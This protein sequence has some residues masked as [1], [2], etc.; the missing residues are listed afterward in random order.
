MTTH[1]APAESEFGKGPRRNK[2]AGPRASETARG[3]A[4]RRRDSLRNRVGEER[5]RRPTSSQ[6]TESRSY[7]CTG[8][9]V[10]DDVLA[11]VR[12]IQLRASRVVNDVL[13]GHYH[14]TFRG[15]G[16]EFDE[17]RVYTPGDDVRSIDW[18][19][20]ARTGVPHIKRYVE[21]RELTV[22]LL[23]DVS[24]S[25]GF[26]SVRRTRG[27]IA[28]ELCALLALAAIANDDKVGLVL[29]AAGIERQ[30]PPKKGRRNVLRVIR[31]V[32][33]HRTHRGA[34]NIAAAVAHAARAQLRHAT[35]FLVS[36]FLVDGAE[37]DA[38]TVALRVAKRRHDVVAIT[39]EDPRERELPVAG[40]ALLRDLETGAARLVDMSSRRVRE[41]FAAQAA[42]RRERRLRAFARLGIDEVVIDIGGDWVD[43]LVRFFMTRERRARREGGG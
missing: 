23:V 30:V 25:A 38:L 10:S 36:D 29:F 6:P 40:L 27:E 24:A 39:L 22:Q 1:G 14:S 13:A 34:T 26:G 37:W 4:A 42:E 5:Q 32:L 33:L 3:K 31:E 11:A 35:F 2:F 17:V 19:V 16:M 28:A 12:R 15:V 7:S 43:P 41:A 18:N 20:T 21:E 8:P 9:D